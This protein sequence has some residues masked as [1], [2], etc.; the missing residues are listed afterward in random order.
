MYLSVTSEEVLNDPA[1]DHDP[2]IVLLRKP[3]PRKT[4]LATRGHYCRTPG[5]Y[6]T[7]HKARDPEGY[8]KA[9]EAL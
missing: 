1:H 6:G 9:M 2:R 5:G 7:L 3:C 4:C 8:R